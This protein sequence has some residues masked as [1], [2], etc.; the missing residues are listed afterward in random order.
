MTGTL[1]NLLRNLRPFA[2]IIVVG[3]FFYFVLFYFITVEL[4]RDLVVV[5]FAHISLI[6]RQY[7]IS[8]LYLV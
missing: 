7:I 5:N 2:G 8:L 4:N 1:L 3:L 6:T